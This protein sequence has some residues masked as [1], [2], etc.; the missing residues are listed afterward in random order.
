MLKKK[1]KTEGRQE[2]EGDEQGHKWRLM[3]QKTQRH[4]GDK[5][6]ETWRAGVRHVEGGMECIC[7]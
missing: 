7:F 6:Q 1:K 4:G 5:G 3:W 2:S